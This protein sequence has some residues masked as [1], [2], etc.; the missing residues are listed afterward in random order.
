MQ[1]RWGLI[2][3]WSVFGRLYAEWRAPWTSRTV[4]YAQQRAFSFLALAVKLSGLIKALSV[5]KCKSWYIHLAVWVV[6]LQMARFGDLWAY[7]TSPVEQRGARLKR[8]CRNIVSWRPYHDGWEPAE[9]PGGQKVWKA[10]RKWNSSAMMQLMRACCSNEEM[11]AEGSSVSDLSSL[12]CSE[13]RM[14]KTGRTTLLKIER[15]NGSRLAPLHEE[16]IDLT[17]DD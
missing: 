13:R 3:G 16:V 2:L 7:G 6:P 10:R 11:W 8:F 17:W 1:L 4:E 14:L 15:G 9:N 5:G 12:S